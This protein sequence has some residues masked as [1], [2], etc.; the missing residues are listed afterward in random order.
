[1]NFEKQNG[2]E[3]ENH[4]L[5]K[6]YI[7]FETIAEKLFREKER[8][9]ENDNINATGFMFN[10]DT[11]HLS[12]SIGYT[13]EGIQLIYNQYEVASYADGPITLIVPFG[14]VNDFLKHKVEF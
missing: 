14:E 4:Q 6:D 11:F 10:G 9:S 13:E 2:V 7:G 3:L 5:F 8:L 12:E 1:M